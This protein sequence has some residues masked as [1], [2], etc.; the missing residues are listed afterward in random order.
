MK[1]SGGEIWR[2]GQA[3]IKKP[4]ESKFVEKDWG[5]EIWMANNHEENY[6]GKILKIYEGYKSSMHYHLKK[7]ETFYI[8]SGEL[9]V[10][11]IYTKSG[12][13]GYKILKEGDVM[14][15]ERGQPHQLIAY[16]GDV[17]FVETSTFHED[18]D[19]YRVWR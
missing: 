1:K 15:I 17:E 5:Y 4:I 10:D 2:E 19:S 6:C 8:L 3:K 13:T 14:E 18:S 7:H 16:D 9:R 12:N 11:L